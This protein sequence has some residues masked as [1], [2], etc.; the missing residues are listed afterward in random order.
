MDQT[1]KHTVSK[2]KPCMSTL[3]QNSNMFQLLYKGKGSPYNRPWGPKR[4]S[5]DI[6]LPVWASARGGDGVASLTLRPLYLREWDPVPIVQEAGWAP[7]PVWTAAKFLAPTE[8]RSPDR[9]ARSKSIYWLSYRGPHVSAFQGP[10]WSSY[11]SCTENSIQTYTWNTLTQ[12]NSIIIQGVRN[13][14]CQT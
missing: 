13:K 4:G 14:V 2:E 11:I 5:R 1:N 9:Q 6:A 8:I 10:F 12:I 3:C 7:G